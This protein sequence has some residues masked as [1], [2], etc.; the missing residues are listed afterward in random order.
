MRESIVTRTA[1]K[2]R[3]TCAWGP[4]LARKGW[5]EKKRHHQ[6]FAINRF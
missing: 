4:A 6:Y 5:L 2:T 1:H 3:A